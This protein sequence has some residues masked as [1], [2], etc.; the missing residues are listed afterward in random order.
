M[1][2]SQLP[3]DE[4]ENCLLPSPL[5]VEPKTD[6]PAHTLI[7]PSAVWAAE[8]HNTDSRR[9]QL[10]PK[11]TANCTKI[12]MYIY[13]SEYRQKQ[14]LQIVKTEQVFRRRTNFM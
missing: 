12:C 10:A 3:K 11:E 5:N 7:L 9:E 8:P 13:I 4:R 6:H 14:K 2:A 1:A